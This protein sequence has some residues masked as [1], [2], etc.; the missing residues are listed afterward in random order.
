MRPRE[1]TLRGFR[2]FADQT[3]FRFEGRGLVGIVGPI[4]SGKSSILDAISFGL[5]G[6]TPKIERDTKSLIS[7]RRNSLHV[8]LVFEVDGAAWRVVRSL[9]RSGAPAHTLYRTDADGEHEVADKAR[10]VTERISELLGMEFEAFRRSVL[11]A[12]NQFAGF[13]EA[14]PTERNQV[15][16]GGFGFDRLDA[17]REVA[18]GRLD[19]MEHVA[20]PG[21]VRRP[22]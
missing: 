2:S 4:G 15:L 6:K 22:R 5:Y 16:K 1:L 14:T 20:A 11:L 19:V 9:R 18:K 21:G 13:L 7:Q 3:T 8:E 12:Q 17:M 10:E